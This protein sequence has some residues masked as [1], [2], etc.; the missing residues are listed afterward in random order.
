MA[1]KSGNLVDD[2]LAKLPRKGTTPWHLQLSPELL[3]E[4]EDI[5]S[6]FWAG[7]FPRATKT[8][9]AH[10]LSKSLRDRG[11]DIGFRG[12]EKWLQRDA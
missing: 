11:V 12:V 10:A 5:R 9:M 8:G 3:A 6:R 4:V 2:V 7:E 1:K